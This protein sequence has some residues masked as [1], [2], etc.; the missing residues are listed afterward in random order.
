MLT[1][2]RKVYI[3][4]K[5]YIE[6]LTSF[7][8][9]LNSQKSKLDSSIAKLSNGVNKLEE[10]N[11]LIESLKVKLTELQPVLEKKTIEQEN[12]LKKL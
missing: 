6:L 8:A 7:N 9:F 1:T 10:T 12:L 4:P 5:N 11:A 2:R 3:T